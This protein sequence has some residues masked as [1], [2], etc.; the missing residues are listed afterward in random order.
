M[1]LPNNNFQWRPNDQS[2]LTNIR[3]RIEAEKWYD[4]V[5]NVHSNQMMSATKY[6]ASFNFI[7][8]LFSL[9]LCLISLILLGIVGLIKMILGKGEDVRIKRWL[10]TPLSRKDFSDKLLRAPVREDYDTEEEYLDIL[11][12]FLAAQRDDEMAR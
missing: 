6:S 11:G 2:G 10:D 5:S 8:T 3:Y 7:G 12:A 9:V 1:P 4:A